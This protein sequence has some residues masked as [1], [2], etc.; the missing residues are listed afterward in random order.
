M[1]N[2]LVGVTGGIAAYKAAELV[3]LLG[4]Q[5]ACSALCDDAGSAAVYYA[6]DLADVI[7]QSCLY[8]WVFF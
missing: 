2:I 8:R 3:S 6:V 5:G 1:A 7:R 4:K